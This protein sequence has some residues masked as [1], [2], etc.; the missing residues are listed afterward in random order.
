MNVKF[1]LEQPSLRQVPMLLRAVKCSQTS[2][3]AAPAH[4]AAYLNERTS[5]V[6]NL[7]K[8]SLIDV[9]GIAPNWNQSILKGRQG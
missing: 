6:Q 5:M 3:G 8:L 7:L 1:G 4:S 9:L 2:S